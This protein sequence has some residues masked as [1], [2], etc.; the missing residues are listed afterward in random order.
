[1]MLMGK[2]LKTLGQALRKFLLLFDRELVE[3]DVAKTVTKG[4][5]TLPEKSQGK[6]FQ[7]AVEAVGLGEK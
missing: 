3:R 6:A 5:L 4:G 2:L 7:E 1:M